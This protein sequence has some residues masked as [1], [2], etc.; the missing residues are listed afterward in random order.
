VEGFLTAVDD[1][2][3]VV[4]AI[5]GAKDGKAAKDELMKSWSL[6]DTQADAVLNLSL[7]RLTGLAIVELRA[8][9]EALRNETTKLE[10]L[11]AD[12]VRGQ[13]LGS[14]GSVSDASANMFAGVMDLIT[15]DLS[16]PGFKEF[17]VLQFLSSHSSLL[18]QAAVPHIC[19]ELSAWVHYACCLTA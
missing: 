7:R 1:L 6:T 11:L 19:A 2:S 4:K 18:R 10:A 17:P 14:I 9:G 5:R 13:D 8:E 16:R 3:G 12:K 15:Q